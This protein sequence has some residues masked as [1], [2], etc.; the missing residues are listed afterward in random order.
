M[1]QTS[2]DIL[3]IVLSVS[4]GVFAFF[5]C[6]AMWYLVMSLRKIFKIT[7]DIEEG[8]VE[9]KEGFIEI[10]NKLS[11]GAVAVNLLKKAIEGMFLVKTVKKKSKK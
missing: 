11:S 2:S 4:I 7:K 9:V 6:W 5:L 10:K 3:N 8:V 1:L